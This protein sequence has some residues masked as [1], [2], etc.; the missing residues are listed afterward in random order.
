MTMRSGSAI[1]GP[2]RGERYLGAKSGAPARAAVDAQGPVHDRY[3]VGQAGEAETADGRLVEPAAVVADLDGQ[4][5]VRLGQ[6][7]EHPTR[8]GV[9]DRVGQRLRDDVPGGGLDLRG[10]ADP[11]Q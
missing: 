6:R 11:P 7:D 8:P 9:L 2:G 4:V 1:A 3:P 5:P 10:I